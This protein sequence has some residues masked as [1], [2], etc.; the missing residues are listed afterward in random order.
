MD[1]GYTYGNNNGLNY[2]QLDKEPKSDENL[3]FNNKV[4]E[5]VDDLDSDHLKEIL[6]AKV[7]LPVKKIEEMNSTDRPN[8]EETQS[9]FVSPIQ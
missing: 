2:E 9:M 5:N 6:T 1:K 8:N 4:I 3:T 7:L